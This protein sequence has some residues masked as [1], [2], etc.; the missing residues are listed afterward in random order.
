MRGSETIP[1]HT[2]EMNFNHAFSK[3]AVAALVSVA[4]L[5]V[6]G[7][8]QDPVVPEKSPEKV[9]FRFRGGDP[10]LGQLAFAALNCIQCHSVKNRNVPAPA[11][12]RRIELIL[13]SKARFVKD[14]EDLV[15][16]ITSPRHVMNEQYLAIINDAELQGGLEPLMPD[17]TAHMTARQ[18]IDLTAFLHQLYEQELPEYGDRKGD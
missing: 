9:G 18:L 3:W 11:E 8:A 17:L 4:I 14:Y 6:T 12:R 7:E 1:R 10:E 5:P 2:G 15:L 16:A 13:A